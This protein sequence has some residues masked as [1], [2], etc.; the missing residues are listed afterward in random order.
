MHSPCA[1]KGQSVELKATGVKVLGACDGLKYPIAKGLGKGKEKKKD[2]KEEKQA[3]L[4]HLR[5]VAHL[6]SRS[7]T[8]CVCTLGT[9]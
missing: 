3:A 4:E 8:V 1:A 7:R 5:T 6:R 2:P 9:H